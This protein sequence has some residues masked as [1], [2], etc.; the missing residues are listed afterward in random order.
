MVHARKIALIAMAP[1]LLLASCAKETSYDYSDFA[2][3][4]IG[5]SLVFLGLQS[6]YFVYVYSETCSSCQSVKQTVL[7]YEKSGK[8]ELYLLDITG[9]GI[10]TVTSAAECRE[11]T[12]G[13]TDPSQIV[14]YGTPTMFVLSGDYGKKTIT[15]VKI[16]KFEIADFLGAN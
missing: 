1:A 10:K 2:D 4:K 6:Q 3:N 5:V 15:D 11:K 8:T 7:S 12:I 9:Q 14:I 13:A 16:G